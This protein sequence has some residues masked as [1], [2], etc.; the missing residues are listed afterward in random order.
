VVFKKA[1]FRSSAVGQTASITNNYNDNRIARDSSPPVEQSFSFSDSEQGAII[2]PFIN[3]SEKI[4]SDFLVKNESIIPLEVVESFASKQR[5]PVSLDFRNADL[6]CML[7]FLI[8]NIN[9]FLKKSVFHGTYKSNPVELLSSFK[10]NVRNKLA[11]GIIINEKGRWSDHALEH[12][13]ILACEVVIC[14]GKLII[15]A[16]EFDFT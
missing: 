12:V 5:P 7:N 3:L 14:L 11:H 13:A 8:E 6:L 2:E 1:R 10:K 16:Q 4:I 9:I 15:R